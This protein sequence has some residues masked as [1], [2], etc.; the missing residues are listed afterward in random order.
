MNS[1]ISE[2]SNQNINPRITCNELDDVISNVIN[3]DTYGDIDEWKFMLEPLYVSTQ[4]YEESLTKKVKKLSEEGMKI[5]EI[6]IVL[7]MP[8]KNTYQY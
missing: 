8:I 5:Y 2:K 4:E 3:E 1:F 7:N 6:S